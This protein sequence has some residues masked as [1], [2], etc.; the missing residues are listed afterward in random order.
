[1]S[2]LEI[3]G[4]IASVLIAL[5][6]TMNS[7]WR[8][9]WVNLVGGGAMA[10][11]GFMLGAYPIVAVNVFTVSVNV[12]HL[13]KLARAK[14]EFRVIAVPSVDYPFLRIFLDHYGE[15]IAQFQPGF[16]LAK[17]TDPQIH[18]IVRNVVSVG[19]FVFE[20]RPGGNVQVHLDYVVPGYR[21]FKQAHFTYG[22][23]AADLLARGFHTFVVDNCVPAHQ[24]YL[25]RLGFTPDAT[26]AARW[27]R[28]IDL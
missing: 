12:F 1:M 4:Y 3:L 26:T 28:P 21:D 19:L 2:A 13:W 8:L 14:H 22:A 7:L 25:A 16:D 5:S 11:Y 9:R 23:R 17:L 20:E 10:V 27:T 24:R 6:M 15:D 18:F